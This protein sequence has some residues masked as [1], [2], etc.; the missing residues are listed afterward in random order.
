[1]SLYRAYR[2]KGK[3]VQI[4]CDLVTVSQECGNMASASHW[5]TGKAF[6]HEDRQ[7]RKPA[8]CWYGNICFRSRGIGCT[9]CHPTM[10]SNDIPILLPFG[11]RIFLS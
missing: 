8:F 3:Q 9:V 2:L 6:L 10:M 7:V 4:L 1:M 5:A 11:K